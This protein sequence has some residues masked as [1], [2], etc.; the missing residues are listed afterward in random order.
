MDFYDGE[1]G[2]VREKEWEW[3]LSRDRETESIFTIPY[4]YTNMVRWLYALLLYLYALSLSGCMYV[5][6]LA[7]SGAPFIFSM[8]SLG[9]TLGTPLGLHVPDDAS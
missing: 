7:F 1:N 5:W 8:L 3:I 9:Q 6:N 4:G 2:E